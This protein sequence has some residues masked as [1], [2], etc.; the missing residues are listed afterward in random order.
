MLGAA[1]AHARRR[2]AATS[3]TSPRSACRPTRRASRAYVALQGRAGRVHARGELG[4]DRRQR[5]V[6]DDPHAAR[7]HADD[8]AD[9][10]VRLVPDDHAGRGRRPGLRGDPR[11]AEADQHARS[12]RSA[13]SPTRSRRRPST[14]SCTWPTRSSRSQP[15]AKGEKDA[16]GEGLRRGD[17]ARLPDAGRALV[18]AS[19]ASS[20]APVAPPRSPSAAPRIAGGSRRG[21][22]AAASPRGCAGRRARRACRRGRRR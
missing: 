10:D 13:R 14:R 3:S 8:R 7:A 6:H 11:E 5:H 19:R 1:A 21:T 15:A 20:A 2:A 12:A 4:D 22:G 17:R 9:E 16:D 18:A